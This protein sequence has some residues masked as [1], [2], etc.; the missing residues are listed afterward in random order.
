[1]T[2][3][4]TPPPFR[5][6]FRPITYLAG[7]QDYD[8]N[9]SS[10]FPQQQRRLEGSSMSTGPQS[11]AASVPQGVRFDASGISGFV[12]DI[13]DESQQNEAIQ[14]GLRLTEKAEVDWSTT[15]N[16]DVFQ[17]HYQSESGPAIPTFDFDMM[18]KPASGDLQLGQTS[19]S[20][21]DFSH[22]EDLSTAVNLPQTVAPQQTIVFPSSS[23]VLT[24]STYP[25]PQ[26]PSDTPELKSD[27]DVYSSPATSPLTPLSPSPQQKDRKKCGPSIWKQEETEEDFVHART[28]RTCRSRKNRETHSRWTSKCRPRSVGIITV[29]DPVKVPNSDTKRHKCEECDLHFERPEHHKRHKLAEAHIQRCRDLGIHVADKD[30]K[31]FKCKVPKCAIKVKGVTRRD[32]LKP[33]YQKTHFFDKKPKKGDGSSETRKR[34][35]YVSPRYAHVALGLGEWDPRTEDG[36]RWLSKSKAPRLDPSDSRV[37]P[38]PSD[39][40]DYMS[41]YMSE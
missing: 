17:S 39:L 26:S 40:S 12:G 13:Y 6:D 7:T 11:Q 30:P 25:L 20:F 33:H 2:P 23:Y 19:S 32:N 18:G 5:Q 37:D 22:F 9:Y 38:Y 3:L 34:N 1:M 4:R 14:R 21:A 41:D 27:H 8:G 10:M 24:D 15:F 36:A 29:H 35:L 28:R 31:P 16:Q